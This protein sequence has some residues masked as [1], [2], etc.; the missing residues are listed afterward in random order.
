[1]CHY[2]SNTRSTVAKSVDYSMDNIIV[3]TCQ[4]FNVNKLKLIFQYFSDD[5][6]DVSV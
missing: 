6:F 2:D 1:M 4:N 5:V 3:L